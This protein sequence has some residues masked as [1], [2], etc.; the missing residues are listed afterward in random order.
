MEQNF[1]AV[2]RLSDSR[3]TKSEYLFRY[4]CVGTGIDQFLLNTVE[5]SG[6]TSLGNIWVFDPNSMDPEI[7]DRS[8]EDCSWFKRETGR[9]LTQFLAIGTPV[10][11]SNVETPVKYFLTGY[12][13]STYLG[14]DGRLHISQHPELLAEDQ[15]KSKEY[16][17]LRKE[18]SLAGLDKAQRAE[19]MQAS[20]KELFLEKMR[21]MQKVNTPKVDLSEID[22]SAVNFGS[23][24]VLPPANKQDVQADFSTPADATP[25]TGDAKS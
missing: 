19:T 22:F 2:M 10:L 14:K 18:M 5:S 11:L 6:R 25:P 20:F 16:K 9:E 1:Q 3:S 17:E 24:P 12:R 13:A 23:V 21:A 8:L 7:R 15:R 4:A